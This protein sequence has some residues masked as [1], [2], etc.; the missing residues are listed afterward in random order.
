MEHLN[1][2]T[3][4]KD[5]SNKTWVILL[6]E[7]KPLIIFPEYLLLKLK[8][9]YMSENE[10]KKISYEIAKKALELL[11]VTYQEKVKF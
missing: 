5:K 2:I 7:I 3:T 4:V 6:T 1:I 11:E 9:L 10:E 8:E